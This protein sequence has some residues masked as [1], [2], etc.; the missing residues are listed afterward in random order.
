MILDIVE[1][2][3]TPEFSWNAS[4][5]FTIILYLT[6]RNPPNLQL[7]SPGSPMVS[8]RVSRVSWW[9]AVAISSSNK[10][11]NRHEASLCNARH[12]T[13]ETAKDPKGSEKR[14]PGRCIRQLRS[15]QQVQ[16]HPNHPLAVQNLMVIFVAGFLQQ[17]RYDKINMK[18]DLNIFHYISLYF[19]HFNALLLVLRGSDCLLSPTSANADQ[20]R[21]SHGSWLQQKQRTTRNLFITYI[22]YKIL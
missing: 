22:N 2:F 10:P 3:R 18:H 5:Y 11:L 9:M 7:P 17:I 13:R 4:Q 16:G 19:G 15:G 20:L 14:R 6:W 21:L 1:N 12:L 8:R